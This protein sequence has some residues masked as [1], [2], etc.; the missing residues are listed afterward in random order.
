M[1]LASTAAPFL[2][3]ILVSTSPTAG[4][5]LSSPVRSKSTPVAAEAGSSGRKTDRSWLLKPGIFGRLSSGGRRIAL[6]WNGLGPV[7][8]GG[9]RT[10]AATA[11]APA[12]AGPP[13]VR[14]NVRVNNPAMD[15]VGHTNSESSI[16][17]RSGRI[18]V[19]FNG[20]ARNT[21][22]WAVSEDG[23]ASFLHQRLPGPPDGFTYG[24]PAVAFGPGGEVYYATMMSTGN[25]TIST[26]GVSKSTDGGMTFSAPVDAAADVTDSTSLQD[27]EWLAVDT[28]ASSSYRGTVYVSWT[29][30]GSFGGTIIY[31]TRS[32]DGG[33]T[34]DPPQPLS[35]L[36]TYGVRN[37]VIAVGPAGEVYVA[38]EDGHIY[39]DGITVV[40]STDGGSSFTG[41]YGV[42]AFRGLSVLTGGGGVRASS[43]PTLAVDATGALHL[44]FAAT[45]STATS[46]R[47]DI[48]YTRS[49]N[50]GVNWST[51][52]TLND[53][54]TATTQAFPW[55]AVAA[56]GSVAVKWADRRNDARND[57]LTDVYMA[58]SRDGGATWGKNFRITDTNWVYGPIEAG[59]ASGYHGE[60]DG[61]AADGG[62]FYLSW[63]DER[64]SDPGVYFAW[65][66]ETFDGSTPDA[67]V[68]AQQ[69]YEA[70]RQGHS[71]VFDLATAGTNG[72]S[73]PLSL[74]AGPALPGLTFAFSAPTVV[75]GGTVQLTAS[76][77]TEVPPGDYHLTVTASGGGLSRATTIW[78]TVYPAARPVPVP[79][80]VTATAGFTGS[81]GVVADGSGRLHLLYEDDTQ[82]VQGE[83]VFYR[84]SLDG[85]VTWS[86]PLK[87]NSPASY[88]VDTVLAADAAGHVVAVW[89]G[90]ALTDT[91]TFIYAARSSDGGATFSAP[92]VLTPT[93]QH[94]VYP[95]VS[96][97]RSGNPMV[98]YVEDG[99]TSTYVYTTRAVG[100]GV[101]DTPLAIP[102]TAAATI[103]RP[104]FAYDS[105]GVA[106]L[107]YTRQVLDASGQIASNVRL[108][109][110]K[111]GRNFASPVDLTHAADA[112]AYAPHVAVGP[113]D[114]V[115]IAYYAMLTT[116]SGDLNREVMLIRSTDGGGTFSSP[117]N[118]SRNVGQSTFPSVAAETS[119]AIDVVWEDDLG[120]A[121]SD[122]LLC[123]SIDAGRTF[124]PPLNVSANLG[125][126]GSAANPLENTGGSGRSAV[127]A[128]PNGTLFI[129]WLDD[130]AANPDVFLVG[131]DPARL[132]NLPPTASITS[133]APG[134]SVEAGV[135]VSFSGS[136]SDP[137]GG[138]LTYAWDFGDGTTATGSSPPAHPFTSAGT[139]VVI[140]T[141]TDPAGLSAQASVTVTVT[142]PPSLKLS[143]NRI[144]V[145]VVWRNPYSG[146]AGAAFNLP[147][148]DQFGYFYFTDPNNPEVFV[149]VLDFGSGSALCF[150]GGLTDFYYKV[151][152]TMA[153]T[154]QTLVFEKP[155]YQYIGYVNNSDLKFSSAPDGM[156]FV[157]VL[158]TA[159]P[160]AAFSAR[161]S[162][163][164]LAVS[165]Q[166]LDFSS[167]RVRVTIDWQ[168]PYSGETGTAYGIP[169]ADAFGF[170]YYTDPTNPEVFVK[171]LDFGSGS[172]L[173]FVGGLTDFY[174]KVTFTVL[175]TGQT[176]V[177]EKQPYQ[178][179]GF[180]DNSTL[181]F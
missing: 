13:D 9:L 66:P 6:S 167:G 46:D 72:F 177:F 32:R 103:T 91:T 122:V 15:E 143:S 131:A 142:P 5:A 178:Y 171:V 19:G 159:E 84:R 53:D 49:V 37:P 3:F 61:L 89:V 87:L 71:A 136:G 102:E 138:A 1:K 94:A 27:K 76:A 170:F 83:D 30:I 52:V 112:N 95:A 144:L 168:N 86:A 21:S 145:D 12:S 124:S 100:G 157:G 99:S 34:F 137:E 179:I 75:P 141:V 67:N 81:G 106:Y 22:A 119:G 45:K 4:A 166:F 59:V 123:R 115:L 98:V 125:L 2:F 108:A 132:I 42:V 109:V 26:V 172:A 126:S 117:V 77:M 133:P 62:S 174:Y 85:G 14:Q 155:A 54:A 7:V 28:N 29:F 152:F 128:A 20:A 40:K 41:P 101:F 8:R 65:V 47:A 163:P 134:V 147:Q 38:F 80:N 180:V 114:S 96:L 74:S 161:R 162:V 39:P 16:A 73:A 35:P 156:A 31:F 154:G 25:D 149:K 150:V 79:S 57:G 48:I 18:V 97:D 160:A 50:G 70:V 64:G 129:S 69:V 139:F 105:K 121:G 88:G 130:S 92:A 181:K 120:G 10:G 107:A 11:V 60:Y 104:G 127:S 158:A 153:R 90:G 116:A 24:D 82:A 51:L 146:Q 23:G 135:P 140:L 151:T 58:I 169:K 111:D 78:L 17:V 43:Y 55:L 148:N 173:V 44:A 33:Q 176:L 113:D 165:P 68:S 56:D 164:A 36:D 118:V 63:S 93:D 110:G 175:R